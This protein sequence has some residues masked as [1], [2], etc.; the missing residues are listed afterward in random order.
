MFRFNGFTQKANNAINISI[1]EASSMGH[2]YIGSEHLL[3]GLA[4]EGSGVAY[5]ILK[6]K[7]ITA[8]DLRAQLLRTIGSGIST[9]LSPDDLTPRC[10]RILEMSIA[11]ARGM[12][13]SYVGTEHILISIIKEIDCFAL[14]FLREL[15]TDPEIVYKGLWEVLGNSPMNVY[16]DR[17]KKMQTKPQRSQNT[18]TPALDKYSIDLTEQ[19]RIN[20][21]DPVIGREKEIDKVIQ[22]LSRRNKN[23]PCLIGEAGVGKTAIIEG[24]AQR[25][26]DDDVTEH[27]KNKRVVSLDLPSMVA[28]TKYRGDF[29]ERIKTVISEVITAG[30]VI[31]FVDEI[32]NIMGIGAAEG[33]VD[34]ANIL[35]PQLAR[36]ELQLIGA[37]TTDEYRK[38]IEKDSALE[39]RF[40]GVNIKEPSE[41]EAIEILRGL[42]NKYE[43]HHKIK[44]TDEAI[45]AAVKLSLRYL[46]DRFLPDKAIDLIDEAAS[47]IKLGAFST[48]TDQR[49][50]EDDLKSI[51]EEKEAAINSQDFEL[52]AQLRDRESELKDKLNSKINVIGD[53]VQRYEKEVSAEDISNIIAIN[54]GI[55]ITA[56]N[57]EQGEKLLN[58]ENNL[59][60]SIIGQDE[61]IMSIS[62]A[63]RR[64]RIGLND[65]QRPI[66]SFIFLGPTGVGKT[67]LSKVL[68]KELF[69]TEKAIIRFDMSEYMEKHD[70]SKLIGSPPGYV[71]YEEGGKLTEKIRRRPYSVL[72]FDEIEKAHPDVFNLMLQILEDGILTDSQGRQVSFKNTLII[73]TSNVG[74]KYITDSKTLGF[75]KEDKTDARDEEIKK[76]ILKELKNVFRPEFLNR[77]DDIVVF[78]I[79]N[80]KDLNLITS[81][82]LHEVSIKLKE[83]DV[84][85]TYSNAVIDNIS[86]HSHSEGYGARPIRRKIQKEIED[87]IAEMLISKKIKKGGKVYCNIKDKKIIVSVN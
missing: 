76:Q 38:N 29:E 87:E 8:T 58:L 70:V 62:R 4:K 14:R 53:S 77:V 22:I 16:N 79:L 81:K 71:G 80:K 48:P 84:E 27:L 5:T 75:Y 73:M 69:G 78:H 43:A 28:G 68:T 64:G 61:A 86:E 1:S 54:T 40:Q 41:Q 74:A 47:K 56:I 10:K 52:A 51:K 82:L 46:P 11:E 35:K 42:K 17:S 19:A 30:N 20:K 7:G 15:G 49:E 39:R 85:L 13:H 57:Q 83:F 12:G 9:I 60:N 31:L 33:A 50:L 66:G 18:K 23:N 6:S 32:H 72:L 26:V 67:E 3:Y 24:L 21:L 37:T 2:T 36:G 25:V 65:P 55:E 63:I 59:K 45:I 34:A 44:I